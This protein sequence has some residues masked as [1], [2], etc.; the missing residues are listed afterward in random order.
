MGHECA[1]AAYST[2]LSRW[3]GKWFLIYLNPARCRLLFG[4]GDRGYDQTVTRLY[5]FV[6]GS[7]TVTTKVMAKV[8][9]FDNPR[10]GGNYLKS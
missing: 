5:P 7:A 6:S 3:T 9:A 2:G 8:V 10:R 1:R 4:W